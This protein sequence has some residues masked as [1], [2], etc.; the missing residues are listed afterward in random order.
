M[1]PGLLEEQAVWPMHVYSPWAFASLPGLEQVLLFPVPL[2]PP[3]SHL[4]VTIFE[5]LNCEAEL[6]AFNQTPTVPC[7]CVCTSPYHA[8]LSLTCLDSLQTTGA[9]VNATEWMDEGQ[10]HVCN[11]QLP[12][13]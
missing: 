11:G 10:S 13:V 2:H 3:G 6:G 4:D 12:L 7:E 9:S 1:C 5:K 8:L